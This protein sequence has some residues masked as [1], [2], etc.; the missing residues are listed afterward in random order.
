MM[1]EV[2]CGL[3]LFVSYGVFLFGLFGGLRFVLDV[4]LLVSGEEFWV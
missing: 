4:E 2:R 3:C 1:V